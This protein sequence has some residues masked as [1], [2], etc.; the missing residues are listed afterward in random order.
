MTAARMPGRATALLLLALAA[1]PVRAQEGPARNLDTYY[2]DFSVP[3]LSAFT[4]LG[5]NGAR[6]S[7]PG[8]V[9][10]LA[11]ALTNGLNTRG[12]LEQGTGLE[13]ALLRVL[14]A[15][16]TL[17]A[18]RPLRDRL[19][20]SGAALREADTT[21]FGLGFRWVLVD[22]ADP[23][24]RRNGLRDSVVAAL[25]RALDRGLTADRRQAY[26]DGLIGFWAALL[27]DSPDAAFALAGAFDVS[28]PPDPLTVDAVT[29]RAQDSLD[30]HGLALTPEQAA[31]VRG[32]AE[33]YVRLV[34]VE[35]DVDVDAEVEAA[36]VDAKR[37]F[38]DRTWN[39]FSVQVAGGGTFRTAAGPGSLA[40]EEVAGFASV[41]YPILP[42]HGQLVA[43]AQVRLPVGAT[44]TPVQATVGGRLLLGTSTRRLSVEAL[45]GANDARLEAARS[46]RFSVGG[47]FRLAD[48]TYLELATGLD[49]PESGASRFLTLGALRY[50]LRSDRRFAIP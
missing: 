33:E 24:D 23:Y 2:V 38:R 19:T 39:A 20:L 45:Y 26:Q 8:N 34:R 47:E 37:R 3:D 13:V 27:P 30:A 35:Q 18:Y 11:T 1:L 40:G 6:V 48:G 41:A 29:A 16:R 5:V 42:R 43:H 44:G 50:A 46:V 28:T 22:R 10:A 7:R 4:L 14:A 25:D 15:P 12:T 9:R 21:R 17:D 49:N 31:R 32:L 36:V